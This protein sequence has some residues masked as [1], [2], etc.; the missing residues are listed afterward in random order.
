MA[1]FMA[2]E[3]GAMPVRFVMPARGGNDRWGWSGSGILP[4]APVSPLSWGKRR[5]RGHG[6]SV[7][8]TVPGPSLHLLPSLPPPEIRGW[9]GARQMPCGSPRDL[10]AL[11]ERPPRRFLSPCC[12]RS[13]GRRTPLTWDP[14]TTPPPAL[15]ATP[16]AGIAPARTAVV[17][18]GRPT[19]RKAWPRE[20]S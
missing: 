6:F 4:S 15:A 18:G 8:A 3:T 9:A 14:S 20:A 7:P 10:G 17:T 2:R 13:M 12:T 19:P 5:K 1:R 11:S 16:H